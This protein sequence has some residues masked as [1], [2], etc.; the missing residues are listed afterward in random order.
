QHQ[1]LEERLEGIDHDLAAVAH[2]VVVVA[3]LGEAGQVAVGQRLVV[4][5][6]D[7]VVARAHVILG[8]QGL[9]QTVGQ[10]AA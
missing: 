1:V 8:F 2:V 10:Q 9:A 3:K 7:D 6:V 5:L 4:E